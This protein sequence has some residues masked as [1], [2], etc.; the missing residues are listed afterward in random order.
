MFKV[1]NR[2]AIEKRMAD[3]ALARLG[4][5]VWFRGVKYEGHLVQEEVFDETGVRVFISAAV[6]KETADLFVVEDS[7]FIDGITYKIRRIPEQTTENA[8]INIELKRA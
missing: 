3:R 2:K 7:V 8:L 4:H 6:K 1:N 5:E